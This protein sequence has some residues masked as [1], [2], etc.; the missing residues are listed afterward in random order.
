MNITATGKA[1]ALVRNIL[2]PSKKTL[3]P[4]KSEFSKPLM[5]ETEK[6]FERCRPEEVGISSGYILDFVKKLYGSRDLSLQSIKMMR[7]GKVFFEADVGLQNSDIPRMTYSESK[8]VV[9]LATGALIDENKLS[10]SESLA[11]IFPDIPAGVSKI[12]MKSITVRN[13]LTMTST[14]TF[15]EAEAMVSRDWVKQF[16]SST[17]SGDHG[18]SFSYNSLNTYMLAAIVKAKSGKCV[19][20]YLEDTVFSKLGISNFYWE[21]CPMGIEK[22]GWGLYIASEDLLKL[23]KLVLDYGIW[24]GKRVISK[25]YISDATTAHAAAPKDYGDFDY[26]YQIWV[27]RDVDKF[28]F[29]GMLGQNLL[30]YRD[31]GIIILINSSN[32]YNFQQCDFFDTAKEFFDGRDFPENSKNDEEAYEKLSELKNAL[33]EHRLFGGKSILKIYDRDR[34]FLSDIE[35]L[36]GKTFEAVSAAKASTGFAPLILQMLQN[37]YTRGLK[38]I[39]FAKDGDKLKMAFVEEDESHI[40]LIGFDAPTEFEADFHGEKFIVRAIGKFINDVRGIPTLVID[41]IF[42]ETPYE[43]NVKV[44]FAENEY[45]IEFSEKP[46]EHF[47]SLAPEYIHDFIKNF[48]LADTV[49]SK[50]DVS[51]ISA[52]L[53]KAS[54]PKLDLKLL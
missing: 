8:S 49:Y 11:D 27:G 37:N 53:L 6:Y 54:S 24:E 42:P 17:T 4:I 15:N 2:D 43:R 1:L 28:L 7:F 13:L 20:E 9:S 34:D 31:S 36:D 48:Q 35:A 40:A 23:G 44:Y 52:R 16:L 29:N 25:K 3:A 46:T 14:V 26:G 38:E 50:I 30:G 33:A 45:K 41:F 39:R 51:H 19:S 10:L 47:I 5:K 21:K 18:A 12:K 32:G 22:G